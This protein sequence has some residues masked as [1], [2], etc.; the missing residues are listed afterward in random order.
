MENNTSFKANWQWRIILHFTKRSCCVVT[1]NINRQVV[2]L[3]RPL[4]AECLQNLAE[5]LPLPKVVRLPASSYDRD[6]NEASLE[7]DQNQINQSKSSD[8]P[9]ER[10]DHQSEL[11]NWLIWFWSN[12]NDGSVLS[13]SYDDRKNLSEAWKSRRILRLQRHVNAMIFGPMLAKL[14]TF[15]SGRNLA[16]FWRHSAVSGLGSCTPCL[17]IVG[18]LRN[19]NADGN[20]DATKQ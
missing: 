3:P 11:F 19:D 10:Q 20:D 5:F 6:R 7:V 12:S 1:Y 18:S 9:K 17:F 13:R 16:K 14:S 8:S 15:G 2:Q 4:T